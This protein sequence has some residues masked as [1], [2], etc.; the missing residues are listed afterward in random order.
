MLPYLISYIVIAFFALFEKKENN[1]IF[2]LFYLLVFFYLLL[3]NGLRYEVGG[4]WGNYL[5]YFYSY[6]PYVSFTDVLF[7][8]DPLYWILAYFMYLIGWNMVGVNFFVAIIFFIGLYLILKKQP[9]P[10]LGLAVAFPYFIAVVSMGYVRQAAAIGFIMI[11]IY[12]L[13]N[14]KFW[15]YVIF[16]LL[17][18]GFHKTAIIMLGIGLFIGDKGKFIKSI[19]ILLIMIGL[20]LAM[21]QQAESLYK[22][23]VEAGI[24]SSGGFIRILMNAV[25]AILLF[26]FKEKWQKLFNDLDFWKILAY[27]SLLMIPLVF[28]S[29]TAVDRIG[30]YFIPLQVVVF[31]RL[32]VLLEGKINRSLI[33]MVILFYYL[34]VLIV[35]F[36]YATNSYAWLPYQNVLFKDLI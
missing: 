22:S 34:L 26:I 35:W 8:N 1:K 28:I 31:S 16:V 18:T 30:L 15:K 29:S 23:Y 36:N 13:E 3:F 5:R 32:P 12:Y 4:D 11:G 21:K 10:W 19:A 17:A 6:L 7:H 14:K 24:Q 27:G 20:G 2:Q 9:Y 33:K 25:A